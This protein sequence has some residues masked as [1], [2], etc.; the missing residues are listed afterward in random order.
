LDRASGNFRSPARVLWPGAGGLR[1]HRWLCELRRLRQ[2]GQRRLALR[3]DEA[4]RHD[5]FRS[6]VSGNRQF[7]DLLGR[8]IEKESGG[9]VGG[10]GHE[11]RNH[12]PLARQGAGDDFGRGRRDEDNRPTALDRKL[13]QP[14]LAEL[15]AGL[16]EDGL[17]HL[18][19]TLVD[20][21]NEWRAIEH[22]LA[23]P[24]QRTA[25]EIGGQEPQQGEPDNRNEDAKARNVE[26]QIGVRRHSVRQTSLQLFSR[27]FI[28]S[29]ATLESP[30]FPFIFAGFMLG[31]V[32]RRSRRVSQQITV[33]GSWL[34]RKWRRRPDSHAKTCEA[35]Q[36][37][38]A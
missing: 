8:D 36:R 32:L 20:A 17:E 28:R 6:L 14:D 10:A 3:L 26:R 15:A 38:T 23:K 29:H 21:A 30:S 33:V 16:G 34:E 31:W 5:E 27:D 2:R 22:R 4:C 13:D 1:L 18:L 24:H 25:D 7:D 11:G 37:Q 9:R 35:H 19:Q 12:R